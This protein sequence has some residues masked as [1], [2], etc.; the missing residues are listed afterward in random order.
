MGRYDVENLEQ[1][2]REFIGDIDPATKKGRKRGAIL[3]TA[4]RLFAEQGYR[5]TSMDDVAAE[6][7]VAKGTL[8]LYF[9]KKVDLLIACAALEKSRWMPRLLGILTADEPA[10]TRLKRWLVAALELP[11]QSPLMTR[12]LEDPEMQ[13]VMADIP[14]SMRTEQRDAFP[15]LM[16]PLLQELAGEDHRWTDVELRDRANVIAAVGYLGPTLRHAPMGVGM[17][18]ERFA[19]IFADFIVDGL[20]PRQGDT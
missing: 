10:A 4:T 13:A 12:L 19:S 20:R 16:R 11:T 5:R 14:E 3:E 17:S 6:V 18:S 15:E 2:M 8:Y 7:G 9:P 1:R